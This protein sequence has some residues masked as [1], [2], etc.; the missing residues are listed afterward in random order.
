MGSVVGSLA[1]G[2]GLKHGLKVAV[3]SALLAGLVAVT[4]YLKKSPVPP[5]WDGTDRRNGL[6][7]PA[8]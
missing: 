7:K 6:A 1:V 4:A 2:D 8:V 3:I 5:G